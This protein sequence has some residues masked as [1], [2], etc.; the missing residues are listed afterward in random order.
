MLHR[1]SK[2]TFR[3]P[4][5]VAHT[6]EL[7][8]THLH[9]SSIADMLLVYMPGHYIRFIDCGTDHEP[10]DSLAFSGSEFATLLPGQADDGST[11]V[12]TPFDLHYRM[13]ETLPAFPDLRGKML[14]DCARG[15]IYEYTIEREALI[16]LFRMPKPREHIQ[17]MHMAAIHL[18]DFELVDKIMML[19]ASSHPDN[20]TPE[21]LKEFLVQVFSFTHDTYVLYLI[22]TTTIIII[23]TL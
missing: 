17:A 6:P 5:P 18:Q 4:V 12:V 14:L 19:L 8:N 7:E 1:K 23:I 15:I 10:C 13:V 21:L 11:V 2:L 16:A 3:F 20:I 9:F 22:T